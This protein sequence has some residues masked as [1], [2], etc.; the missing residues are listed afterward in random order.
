[1]AYRVVFTDNAAEDFKALDAGL[2]TMVRDAIRVHLTHEPTRQSKSPIKRLRDLRHPQ[3]RLRV[4]VV[5]IFYGVIGEDVVVL[6]IMSKE[7]NN[8]MARGAWR[9]MTKMPVARV[10]DNLSRVIKEAGTE[11]VVVTVHGRP[12]AVIIGFQDEDDWLEYR[13][14]RDDKF[15]R[16]ISESRQ[17][18]RKGKYRAFDE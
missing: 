16:R 1:V 10:K 18:Y 11:E 13:L 14:L 5:R 4:G 2:R 12:A 8:R 9:K 7:K 17:Q 3:F 15:L 6:A